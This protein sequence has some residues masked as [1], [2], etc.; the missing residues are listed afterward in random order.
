MRRY[1][2][3]SLRTK[4]DAERKKEDIKF[5]KVTF[6]AE[7]HES[8]DYYDY[9]NVL[10]QAVVVRF[11]TPFLNEVLQLVSEVHELQCRFVFVVVFV[12]G[13]SYCLSP[14]VCPVYN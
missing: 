10:M 12:D 4:Q 3:E 6:V 8:I 14:R 2:Y 11:D 13:K 5:L 1:Q 7:S 9:I